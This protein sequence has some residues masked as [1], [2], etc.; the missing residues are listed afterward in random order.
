MADLTVDLTYGSALY[1]AAEDV[2][3]R[4]EI[5]KNADWVLEV[6]RDN[7]DLQNFINYPAISAR[8]KKETI[9]KI[10]DGNVCEEFL[11]FLYVLID[12]GRTMHLAKITKAMMMPETAWNASPGTA[13]MAAALPNRKYQKIT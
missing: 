4:D 3:K 13:A 6:L 8:E 11:N 10:F 5:A 1:E 12:K 9:E 7:P 2:G